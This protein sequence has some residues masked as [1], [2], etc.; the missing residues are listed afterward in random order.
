METS[1]ILLVCILVT[2]SVW[3]VHGRSLEINIDDQEQVDVAISVEAG[4]LPGK[5][6]AC[7]WALNKVKK[8][9]G[10]NVTSEGVKSKLNIVCNEIGL[11]KSLCR[12]FVNSH[13]WELVEELSTTDDVRTICVNTGACEPKQ[14]SHLLFYP[15][16]EESQTEIIEYS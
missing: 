14:L 8:V 2:C 3:T 1:S 9:M 11:L 7:K 4:K 5:C 13:I 12:K 15:K 16:Q 10:P 6:W